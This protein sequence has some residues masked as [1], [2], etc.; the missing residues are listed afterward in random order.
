M[1]LLAAGNVFCF[2][3]PMIR[4]RDWGRRLHAP[5]RRRP[6][7]LRTKW[8]GVV[9]FAA[10]LAAYE[11]F[12]LWA[13]PRATAVL[14]LA[15]FAAALVVDLIFSGAAFCKYLCPVGQFNFVA[16][17][18]SPLEVRVRE[19]AVCG[20]CRTFDCIKGRPPEPGAAP[21]RESGQPDHRARSPAHRSGNGTLS[22]TPRNSMLASS[23]CRRYPTPC[24]CLRGVR[25]RGG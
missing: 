25:V 10:V 20:T 11:W 8:I 2:G 22:Q 23:S 13:L 6:R 12:D 16:S 24:R 9:L 21:R 1:A 15:Y 14:V 18:M 5:A 19:P 17:T 7:L 4:V 3:C